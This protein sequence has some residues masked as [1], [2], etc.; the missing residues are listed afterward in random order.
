MPRLILACLFCAMTLA[1]CA[2]KPAPTALTGG[3][4]DRGKTLIGSAGCGA[5]H[6]T[7]G[8]RGARGLVGPPLTQI[9]SRSIIAGVLPNTP[10]NL[11]RWI[12][13]PQSVV[14]GNAMPNMELNDHDARDIAAYLETLR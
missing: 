1:A 2:P 14:P 9:A 7:P 12:E 13:A 3:D 10:S 11:I 6:T 5:C 8:V 4:P